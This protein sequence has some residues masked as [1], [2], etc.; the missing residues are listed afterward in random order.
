[1]RS[2]LTGK[3]NRPK[4]K[5]GQNFLTDAAV[6]DLIIGAA[7]LTGT[8]VVIEIGPGLGILTSALA[9]RAGTVIG[10]EIDSDL[11]AVL[12]HT[13]R[14]QENVHLLNADIMKIELADTI[15]RILPDWGGKF[16]V[17]ANIP[18]NLT[19]PLI[20]K[21]LPTAGL[22]VAV[23]MVQKEVAD[24]LAAS[25]GG[26]DYGALSVFAQY[27]S[28]VEIIGTVPK[29]VFNPSPRVDSA[30]VRLMPRPPLVDV[31]DVNTFFRVVRSTF[32][33]RRKTAANAVAAGFGI[34]RTQ[35]VEAM[36][37]AGLDPLRR[38]ETFSLAEFALLTEKLS[39]LSD[40]VKRGE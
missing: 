17:V 11:V 26:K 19:S 10:I 32:A 6:V 15:C 5:W 2:I 38:G 30:V 25:P 18:Y 8:D 27:H 3:K 22:S 16:K 29:E 20:L 37:A 31:K 24:R 36:T 35:V 21:L 13:M 7:D 14:H 12:A 40:I 9:E 1:M 4:K 39:E 33:Q 23:L 28:Q 34:P